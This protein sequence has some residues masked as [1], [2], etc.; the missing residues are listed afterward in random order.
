MKPASK[1]ETCFKTVE[2]KPGKEIEANAIKKLNSLL[3]GNNARH[4]G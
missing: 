1:N 4:A 2:S 3:R